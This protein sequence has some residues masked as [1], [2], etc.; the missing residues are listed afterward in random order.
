MAVLVQPELLVESGGVMFGLDPVTGDRHHV[1]VEAVAGSPS[2][3]VSGS[4]TAEHIALRRRGRII[5]GS[6][7]Q[8]GSLLT[9][10]HRRQLAKLARRTYEAY[11][12]PQDRQADVW[13]GTGR[14]L[15]SGRSSLDESRA[16]F[17]GRDMVNQ[18]RV[19][20]QSLMS[21]N[22]VRRRLDDER[23]RLVRLVAALEDE[24][25]AQESEAESVS[26]LAP[27]SQ[28]PADMAS[29]TFE[30]ERD[31][32]LLEEF[33]EELAEVDRAAARLANSSYGVC[34]GC[35]EQID[36]DRVEAVPAT[37]WCKACQGR[38]ELG[39]TLIPQPST[40]TAAMETFGDAAD[41][42][43]DDDDPEPPPSERSE[44]PEHDAVFI[45]HDHQH[46]DRAT[47]HPS[48]ER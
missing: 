18:N 17:Y 44:G 8:R 20:G 29:E 7:R 40:T 19:E 30:R 37:S 2:A 11:G 6:R 12:Q 47:L 27:A 41:F 21:E 45:H 38:Y 36:P 3:L 39:G 42:L 23:C 4:A 10:R 48:G 13:R 15:Q 25:M 9:G 24:G 5:G 1:V 26:E 35:G 33:R 22:Q 32:G 14:S 34:V 31:L 46:W 43:P 28:H 16:A